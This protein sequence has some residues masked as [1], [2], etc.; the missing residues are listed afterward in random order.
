MNEMWRGGKQL[1]LYT[2]DRVMRLFVSHIH[3]EAPL[4]AAIK[5]E[6][7]TCFGEQ[8]EVFL[9][10]DVPLGKNWLIEIQGASSRRQWSL[11]FSRIPP[12]PALGSI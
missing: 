8:V 6:L 3:E 1:K 12:S 9:A 10:E 4:A 2:S 7:V 5:T 11:S